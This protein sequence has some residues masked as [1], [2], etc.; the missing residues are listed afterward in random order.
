[1]EASCSSD[2]AATVWVFME[3][4]R[5]TSSRPPKVCSASCTCSTIVL[6]VRVVSRTFI[7]TSFIAWTISP[8]FRSVSSTAAIP[9]LT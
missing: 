8:N 3:V 6:V 5:A 9:P 7:S 4:L 2:E 1:M